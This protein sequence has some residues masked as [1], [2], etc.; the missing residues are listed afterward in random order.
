MDDFRNPPGDHFSVAT[1]E[2]LST[3]YLPTG[4]AGWRQTV[5]DNDQS[6]SSAT[7][8]LSGRRGGTGL[9][10]KV[11]SIASF[12]VVGPEITV[13]PR[14]L[15]APARVH[16]ALLDPE[17]TVQV[18]VDLVSCVLCLVDC[19][20]ICTEMKSCRPVGLGRRK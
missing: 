7:G 5:G 3:Y 20:L 16:Q 14:P 17:D 11:L 19:I 12:P 2:H 6:G 9:W 8:L 15:G 1:G 13:G 10:R 4:P 18:R